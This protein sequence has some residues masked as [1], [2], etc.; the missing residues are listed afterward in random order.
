ML[1]LDVPSAA[2]GTGTA[3]LLDGQD[4]ALVRCSIVDA[5]GHL[6]RDAAD[7]VTFGVASGPGAV[8]GVHSGQVRSPAGQTVLNMALI[9]SALH[10]S[11]QFSTPEAQL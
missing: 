2:T 10:R 6:V 5:A 7:V 3:L 8:V 4:T 11:A 9:Q 1:S